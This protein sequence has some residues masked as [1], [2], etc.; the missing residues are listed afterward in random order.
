MN[1]STHIK[2]LVV[3]A[4]SDG[5]IDEAELSILR[6]A[7]EEAGVSEA[8][9]DAWIKDADNIMLSIPENDADR[10]N[11]LIDMIGMATADDTFSQDEYDLCLTIAEKLG[12]DG[13]GEALSRKMCESNLKNLI[14][15]AGADGNIDEKEM[16]VIREAAASA[17]FSEEKLQD[18]LSRGS[19]FFHV[20]PEREEDRETQLIQML[21]LAIADGEFSADEYSL[22]KTVAERLGFTKE[23]L[24]MIIKLSFRGEMK[25]D[26]D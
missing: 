3:L 26:F 1:R 11:H 24:D 9:L 12:Y 14:A 23:E 13:L 17:G 20:I 10:E 4:F 5:S 25:L 15:L 7:A 22:C 16:E 2:N 8:E 19:E 21:S 18:W 6:H